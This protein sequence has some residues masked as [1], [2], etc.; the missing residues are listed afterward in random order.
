MAL[1]IAPLTTTA[2]TSVSGRHAGLAS[3]VNN[4]VSRTASLLCIPVLGIFVFMTFS[5]Q[6]DAETKELDLPREA[7][8]QLEAEKVDLAGAEVPEGLDGRTAAAVQRAIDEAFVAGYRVAMLI[9][10]GLA[11]ASA[12]VAGIMIEGKGRAVE[13]REPGRAGGETAPA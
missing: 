2:M 11:V 6:L 4:A 3:G 7:R 1:V 9:A 5:T 12:V 13:S 10:A 8:Q